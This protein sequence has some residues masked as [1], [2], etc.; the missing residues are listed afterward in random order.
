MTGTIRQRQI[1]SKG[2]VQAGDGVRFVQRR[3]TEQ[4]Y[5][6]TKKGKA[7]AAVDKNVAITSSP[8]A[9]AERLVK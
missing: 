7:T 8:A 4:G 9:L 3:Y 5:S 6:S 2:S 1:S